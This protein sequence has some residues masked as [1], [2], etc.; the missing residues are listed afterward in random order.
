VIFSRTFPDHCVV[1]QTRIRIL[2]SVIEIVPVSGGSVL[3]FVVPEHAFGNNGLAA[4]CVYYFS[5][6]RS[7]FEYF[8]GSFVAR[9]WR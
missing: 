5:Q 4:I 7:I 6:I 1:F 8:A 9:R 3:N 2:L